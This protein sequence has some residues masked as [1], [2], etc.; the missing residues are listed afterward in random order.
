MIQFYFLS[1]L[2]NALTGLVLVRGSNETNTGIEKFVSFS[3][4]NEMVRLIL[5]FAT[6]ATGLL[7]ILSVTQGDIPVIGDLI[8]ALVGLASGFILVLNH[9]QDKSDMK[10][11]KLERNEQIKH[12]VNNKKW[13]GYIALGAAI[14]H[15]LFPT[16]LFL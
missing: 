1:I 9:Y 2:L 6:M 3:I 12:L 5:G 10:M 11:D 4:E 7:K 8:P 15:F 13:I 16:V 14:L